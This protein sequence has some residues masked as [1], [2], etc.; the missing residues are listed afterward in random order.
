MSS[1]Y[2]IPFTKRQVERWIESNNTD[3]LVHAL[4]S[5]VGV[6]DDVTREVYQLKEE[7]G[8]YVKAD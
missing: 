7:L 6:L 8:K 1:E 4:L 2:G 3:D 5:I